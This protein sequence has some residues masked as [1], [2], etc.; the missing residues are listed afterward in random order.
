MD[1]FDRP[2]DI[3]PLI[4]GTAWK[5]DETQRL[6]RY[7]LGAGFW[8]IDT[9][10]QRKHY[11]EAAVGEAITKSEL[12]RETLFIQTKFTHLEG[13]DDRVPYD[14]GADISEQVRQSFHSSLG[15]LQ[16]DYLD[17]YILHGPSARFGLTSD[18]WAVWREMEA[19]HSDG[20]VKYL[21]VSNVSL[22]Q[23]QELYNEAKVKPMFVQNRCFAQMGWD[24]QV[25]QFCLD[26]GMIYQGFS[27]L[28]ANRF[29]FSEPRILKIA[30]SEVMT[31]AQ[32]IFCFAIQSGMLPLTGTTDLSHM[33]EDMECLSFEL[34]SDD[35]KFIEGMVVHG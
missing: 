29:V 16:T 35:M 27:L 31:P 3:P 28:T 23:L 34:S 4:Y 19:I 9:A 5:E 20:G 12:K 10:N 7:A 6:V 25:R 21:G 18:D 24:K 2:K 32:V 8:G 33:D 13:Q 26:N 1:T 30:K 22:S 11:H 14:A 17:S 15:H